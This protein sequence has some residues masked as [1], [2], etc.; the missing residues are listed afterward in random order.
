MAL[1]ISADYVFLDDLDARQVAEMN[2]KEMSGNTIVKG[3]LGIL[4]ELYQ[5]KFI[6][7]AQFKEYLIEI[8]I[9]KDIWISSKLCHRLME[10]LEDGSLD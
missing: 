10:A 5:K 6:S 8:K 1:Q 9:R 7:K 4:T 2:I 3:T